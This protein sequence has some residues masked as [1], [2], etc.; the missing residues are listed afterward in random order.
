M[1]GRCDWNLLKFNNPPCTLGCTECSQTDGRCLKCYEPFLVADE[2]GVCR[3]G[4]MFS[5]STDVCT[6]GCTEIE[7]PSASD[8]GTATTTQKCITCDHEF[9]IL[10][11][12]HNECAYYDPSQYYCEDCTRACHECA[13]GRHCLGCSPAHGMTVYNHEKSNY[14]YCDF[15]TMNYSTPECGILCEQDASS[16]TGAVICYPPYMEVSGVC[17]LNPAHPIVKNYNMHKGFGFNT[18]G[19][20]P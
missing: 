20:S 13:Y 19:K 10:G 2:N 14:T 9:L 3:V 12:E 1:T 6:A 7:P 5:S 17:Q 15:N 8:S 16:T 18:P 11:P 4:P